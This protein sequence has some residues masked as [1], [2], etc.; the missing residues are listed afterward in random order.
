MN[1]EQPK[2]MD[3]RWVFLLMALFVIPSNRLLRHV[4]CAGLERD[5]ARVPTRSNR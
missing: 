2:Q 1:A 4:S 3:R 5:A